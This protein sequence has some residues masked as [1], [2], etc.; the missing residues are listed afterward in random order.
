M[1]S[2]NLQARGASRKPSR[3]PQLKR[4]VVRR[5]PSR[6]RGLHEAAYVNAMSSFD[7]R[8]GYHGVGYNPPCVER[9]LPD[10]CE[11]YDGDVKIGFNVQETNYVV[12]VIRRMVRD[13]N[14]Q[15]FALKWW[16]V[17][18]SNPSV[19]SLLFAKKA[20][21]PMGVYVKSIVDK[22]NDALAKHVPEWYLKCAHSYKRV[23][24][25]KYVYADSMTI[26][27]YLKQISRKDADVISGDVKPNSFLHFHEFSHTTQPDIKAYSGIFSRPQSFRV[28]TST[29]PPSQYYSEEPVVPLSVSKRPSIRHSER[30]FL[31]DNI[32]DTQKLR[33]QRETDI[34][35]FRDARRDVLSEAGQRRI[36]QRRTGE[37]RDDSVTSSRPETVSGEVSPDLFQPIDTTLFP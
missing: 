20:L 34:A 33:H 18:I 32:R 5:R 13:E 36:E 16:N 4:R 6:M 15:L 19:V 31:E 22:I 8:L 37:L 23:V 3:P 28:Q 14:A 12:D 1:P 24:F 9:R 27:D 25:P 17:A 21:T 30:Q 2:R 26:F 10:V 7:P 29:F 35:A 11:I